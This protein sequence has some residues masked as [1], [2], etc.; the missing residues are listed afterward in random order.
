[1]HGPNNF[2]LYRSELRGPNRYEE[3]MMTSETTSLYGSLLPRD[4]K[5]QLES[6][7]IFLFVRIKAFN[8]NCSS[9]LHSALM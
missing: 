4:L 3:I 6:N 8:S 7:G 1:M 9:L 2:R 5:M